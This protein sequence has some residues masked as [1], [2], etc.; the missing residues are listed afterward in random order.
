MLATDKGT[1]SE[2]VF[3]YRRYRAI[4]T[5]DHNWLRVDIVFANRTK[6]DSVLR[7]Y[8]DRIVRKLK[9]AFAR[10]DY[11]RTESIVDGCLQPV[12]RSIYNVSG[13]VALPPEAVVVLG[14]GKCCNVITTISQ[15]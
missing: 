7:D 3:T 9:L 11:I 14:V 4:V 12:G 15:L 5:T 13:L 2:I 6:R 8:A 1:V 10:V